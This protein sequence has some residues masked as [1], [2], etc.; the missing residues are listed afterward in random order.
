MKIIVKDSIGLLSI[1]ALLAFGYYL[2][3]SMFVIV[4]NDELAKSLMDKSFIMGLI[5][6]VLGVTYLLITKE[7][8]EKDK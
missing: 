7:E 4:S 2:M 3:A 5:F 6:M 8:E 1:I